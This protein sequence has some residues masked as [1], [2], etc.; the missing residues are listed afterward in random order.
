MED[1]MTRGGNIMAKIPKIKLDNYQPLREVIFETLRNA[2]VNGDLRPGERLMEVYLA[3]QMGV[4]RTPV[5]EAI[6]KL[7]ADGLVL[8]EPRRGTRVA[9]ISVKDI[10]DVLEVRSMLDRL[11][12]GLAATRIQPAQIKALEAVHKQYANH[13]L[14]EN[15]EG[16][17]K[18]DIEFHDLIYVASGNPRLIAAAAS[19][20]EHIYRF[21][22]IYLRDISKAVDV[23]AEHAGILEALRSGQEK[24]ASAHAEFHIRHQMET[25]ID[26]MSV[27]T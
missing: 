11:A 5:R 16:A 17:I 26:S 21:R 1:D 15:I 2:I 7:E 3:E 27:K 12:T 10:V 22:V 6:R 20:R 24:E 13:V 19:L 18:K 4:S 14:K 9:E 23:E 25:I 8:M